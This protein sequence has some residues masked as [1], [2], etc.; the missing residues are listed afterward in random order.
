MAGLGDGSDF[1]CRGRAH[2]VGGE[3]DRSGDSAPAAM[4]FLCLDIRVREANAREE[5]VNWL[6]LEIGRIEPKL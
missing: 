2:R 1:S 6:T 3:P 4:A 5:G